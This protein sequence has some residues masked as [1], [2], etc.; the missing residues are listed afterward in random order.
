LVEERPCG[1]HYGLSL[2]I[3]NPVGAIGSAG[4]MLDHLGLPDEA[5]QIQR[6]IERTCAAGILSPDVGGTATTED[7]TSAIIDYLAD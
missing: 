4:L 6:A 5:K 2:G 3:C 1:R 7:V